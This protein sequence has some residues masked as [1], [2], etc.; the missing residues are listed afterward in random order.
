ML[1]CFVKKSSVNRNI[2]ILCNTVQKISIKSSPEYG[3]VS[4]VQKLAQGYLSFITC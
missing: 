3:A 1:K 4:L 2:N